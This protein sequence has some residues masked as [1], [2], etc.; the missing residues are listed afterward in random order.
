M[1]KS[2][3]AA[4][5]GELIDSAVVTVEKFQ[6]G[7]RHTIIVTFGVGDADVIIGEETFLMQLER[8]NVAISRAMAK[9]I[10]VMPQTLAGHVPQDKKALET[11]HAIKDY[12]DEFCNQEIL[13]QIQY[14]SEVRNAKLRYHV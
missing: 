13:A 1:L 14:G 7:D 10:V 3:F 9:C 11:A 12:V 6:G 4:D 5:H 8:T 2:I